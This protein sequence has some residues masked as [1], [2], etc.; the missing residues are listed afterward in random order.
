MSER[1]FIVWTL[2]RTGGTTF[3][4]NVMRASRFPAL[5]H[6]PFLEKRP[7]GHLTRAFRDT[8]D[9][10]ALRDGIEAALAPE[11]PNV[12]HVIETLP[13]EINHALLEVATSLGYGHLYLDR[14]DELKRLVSLELAR[15]TGAWGGGMAKD[16]YP[17]IFAGEVTPAAADIDWAR[18]H[19]EKCFARRRALRA[20]FDRAGIRPKE[21][22]FED[23]YIAGGFARL[24]AETLAHLEIPEDPDPARTRREGSAEG[25]G[26]NSAQIRDHVPGMDAFE[27]ELSAFLAAA[28]YAD[29]RRVA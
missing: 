21:V 28:G 1:P 9:T 12:K 11:R 22:W 15:A 6:E 23:L 25:S 18:T 3:A 8:R 4:R 14:G 19:A 20:A 10:R 29:S 17:K 2:R 26:Q 5:Q 27:A 24:H 7:L 16:I 13:E